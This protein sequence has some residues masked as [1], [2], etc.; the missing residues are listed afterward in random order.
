MSAYTELGHILNLMLSEKYPYMLYCCVLKPP[1]TRI[2][3]LQ[4]T[5]RVLI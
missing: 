4:I 2:L 1:S 3:N 5:G